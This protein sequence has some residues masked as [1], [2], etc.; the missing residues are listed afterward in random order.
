[1]LNIAA[2]SL[3]IRFHYCVK[4]YPCSLYVELMLRKDV[5]VCQGCCNKVPHSGWLKQ[6]KFIV[7][8]LWRLE[9]QNQDNI[10][11]MLPLGSRK[12]SVL[13]LSHSFW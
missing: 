3:K 4:V 10:K 7:L 11:A 2:F 8:L 5:L 9:V 12:A 1:M 13:D 6:Q